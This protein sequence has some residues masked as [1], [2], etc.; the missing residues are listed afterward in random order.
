MSKFSVEGVRT[1]ETIDFITN[2]WLKLPASGLFLCFL[3]K[4]G[5]LFQCFAQNY[6]NS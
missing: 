6:H 4:H 1:V 3:N 5:V 2:G